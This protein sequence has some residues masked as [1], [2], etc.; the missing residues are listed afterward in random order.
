MYAISIYI[1]FG[2]ITEDKTCRTKEYLNVANVTDPKENT[3]IVRI[4]DIKFIIVFV[5][6]IIANGLFKRWPTFQWPTFFGGPK[7]DP[8]WPTRDPPETTR[9][10]P[11]SLA[12]PPLFLYLW[13]YKVFSKYLSILS[14]VSMIFCLGEALLKRPFFLFLR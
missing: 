3:W 8:M 6:T 1:F 13:L 11:I 9:T 2:S 12:Q 5:V 4:K 10:H 7:L 14:F